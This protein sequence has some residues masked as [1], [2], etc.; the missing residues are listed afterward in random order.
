MSFSVIIHV[1]A[2]QAENADRR[3]GTGKPG[4]ELNILVLT[5]QNH[6]KQGDLSRKKS[7]TQPPRLSL[8]EKLKLKNGKWIQLP[9]FP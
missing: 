9:L 4:T 3:T 8:L 7:E 5:H 6:M 2:A 1:D